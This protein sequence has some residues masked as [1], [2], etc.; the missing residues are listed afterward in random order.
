MEYR[1]VPFGKVKLVPLINFNAEAKT[2]Q[3]P[4]WAQ[5]QGLDL[6]SG[7]KVEL[8]QYPCGTNGAAAVADRQVRTAKPWKLE[9]ARRAAEAEGYRG[10][11]EIIGLLVEVFPPR[12]RQIQ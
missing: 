1:V 2:V 7:E 9:A 10:A 5:K 6:L 11:V 3:L 8:E 12:A 4:G